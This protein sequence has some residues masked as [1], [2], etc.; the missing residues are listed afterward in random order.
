MSPIA[1]KKCNGLFV[2]LSDIPGEEAKAYDL[3]FPVPVFCPVPCLGEGELSSN[4]GFV[5]C[6]VLL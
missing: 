2:V 3:P 4:Y 1:S 5:C 6:L